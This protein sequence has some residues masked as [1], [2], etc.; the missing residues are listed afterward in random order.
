MQYWS[1]VPK[2]CGHLVYDQA[3]LITSSLAL[4]PTPTKP[5]P[6]PLHCYSL[7][8][9]TCVTLSSLLPISEGCVIEFNVTLVLYIVFH[10]LRR[11]HQP[12]E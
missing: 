3:T 12:Y 8:C 11:L 7:P 9:A 4:P 1:I 10:S 2:I 6:P 5:A